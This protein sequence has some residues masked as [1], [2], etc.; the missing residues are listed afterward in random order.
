M[1]CEASKWWTLT[2]K[3]LLWAQCDCRRRKSNGSRMTFEQI[4][5]YDY[6]LAMKVI[7]GNRKSVFQPINQICI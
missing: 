2:K 4:A 7:N 6:S 1:S 3:N 5:G